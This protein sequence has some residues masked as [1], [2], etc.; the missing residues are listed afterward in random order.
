MRVTHTVD[1]EPIEDL[2]LTVEQLTSDEPITIDIVLPDQHL[3][4]T[5]WGGP[6]C[7]H[8]SQSARLNSKHGA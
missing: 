3:R 7:I 2:Q 5:Y 1:G 6:R 8:V 4:Y